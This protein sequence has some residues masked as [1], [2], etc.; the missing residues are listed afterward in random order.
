MNTDV[1]KEF[2][3]KGNCTGV[4]LIHGF[5]GT[6]SEMRYIGEYLKERGFTVKGIC[7]RGHGTSVADMK[8]TNYRDWINSAVEGYKAL[9]QECDEVFVVGLSM[10]GLLGLYL[11]RNFDVKGIVSMSAPIRI[12]NRKSYLELARKCIKRRRFSITKDFVFKCSDKAVI[13]YDRAPLKS[14]CNL[15]YLIRYVK[16]NLYAIRKP[17]LVLQSYGDRVVNPVSANI[18]YRK[19][20]SEDKSIVY[21]H[22]SGHVITCDCEKELVFEEVY[23]F[24]KSRS[25][26]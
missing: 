4:L 26:H 2:Y 15:F 12:I 23:R 17:L 10:G 13:G 3:Y 19:T 25:K 21:L 22:N 11:A 14:I 7:I 16:Q 18:I 5:C 1:T 6:P 20:N 24:I 9:K 8:K